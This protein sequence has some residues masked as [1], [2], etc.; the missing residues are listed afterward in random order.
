MSLFAPLTGG[1]L[2]SV[3]CIAAIVGIKGDIRE[4]LAWILPVQGTPKF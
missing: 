2:I 4:K 1:A 3:S